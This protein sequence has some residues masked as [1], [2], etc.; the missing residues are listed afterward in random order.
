LR[1]F[2]PGKTG[3]AMAA[4]ADL[5]I[6]FSDVAGD[7]DSWGE[8]Y[9]S[10]DAGG[11]LRSDVL[12]Q[13]CA[14]VRQVGFVS[15][16][17]AEEW[18]KSST[19][20]DVMHAFTW[21]ASSFEPT[22]PFPMI[23]ADDDLASTI[24][25][26]VESLTPSSTDD[27]LWNLAAAC[28]RS[29]IKPRTLGIV[30][31]AVAAYNREQTRNAERAAQI[32]TATPVIEGRVQ[33]TGTVISTDLRETNFGLVLKCLVLDDRGFKVWGNVPSCQ[34]WV[35]G[36][37]VTFMARCERSHND[38]FFGFYTRPTKASKVA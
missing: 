6:M 14:C 3:D 33:V 25:E 24:A 9:G 35:P 28:S 1:D 5:Y 19:A 34:E 29:V 4:L 18:N 8:S 16:A 22:R 11:W 20:S 2:F 26:W 10:G 27:Y 38:E 23:E 37:K 30:V 31:S 12:A 13:A 21:K 17:K 36:D 32:A 7:S 15:K